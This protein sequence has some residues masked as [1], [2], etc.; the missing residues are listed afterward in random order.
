MP[1][2]FLWR[3]LRGEGADGFG[4]TCDNCPDVANPDQRNEDG[5]KLGDAGDDRE[6][7]N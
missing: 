3:S 4:D 7:N 5:G 2:T 6:P 1:D